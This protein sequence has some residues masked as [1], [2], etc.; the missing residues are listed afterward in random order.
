MLFS[1]W[2]FYP[3]K[4]FCRN[5]FLVLLLSPATNVFGAF[6]TGKENFTPDSIFIK[7]GSYVILDK[8][9]VYIKND[10]SIALVAGEAG[11]DLLLSVEES[12]KFYQELERKANSS[13]LIKSIY[14]LVFT[15]PAT[16]KKPADDQESGE[17]YFEQFEN[18]II[19]NIYHYS[20][21]VFGPSVYD[22]AGYEKPWVL[23]TANNL[24]VNTNH[25]VI[26]RNLLFTTGEG[27]EPFAFYDNER[28]L[29]SLPFIED[30]RI[31]IVP[32]QSDTS[33]ADV[34][35]ITK[36]A[37][38]LGAEFQLYDEKSGRIDF[39]D[40]NILGTGHHQ[41]NSVYFDSKKDP[42]W[43]YEGFY[44]I[45]NIAGSF[46]D[47][48]GS[49][50]TYG[51]KERNNISLSRDFITPEIK[52]AGGASV[53]RIR[54]TIT[55]ASGISNFGIENHVLDF[56]AGRSIKLRSF[57]KPGSY[58]PRLVFKTRLSF[59]QY[60]KRP[61]VTKSDNTAYTNYTR[62][63]FNLGYTQT[64]FY[65]ASHIYR[66]GRT[67]DV[68]AGTQIEATIGPEKSEF[69]NRFYMGASAV[70]AG[71]TKNIGYA[72]LKISAGTYLAGGKH[73]QSSYRIEGQ[74]FT[75]KIKIG[76]AR[77]RQFLSFHYTR[78]F[79][80][81]ADEYLN[82]NDDYGIR[83]FYADSLFGSQRCAFRIETVLFPQWYYYGFGAAIFAY[84]DGAFLGKNRLFYH[85]HYYSCLGLG[86]RIRNENLVFNSLE[87]RFGWY[88]VTVPGINK[89]ST[90][91]SNENAPPFPGFSN[92]LP[93]VEPYR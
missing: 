43:G 51:Y 20:L 59:D 40:K 53:S 32:N 60:P 11:Q 44:K 37:W 65:K 86:F 24:H 58:R 63:L 41:E 47:A 71:W 64:R 16:Y 49:Y 73:E 52:Y 14:K 45:P 80:R 21:D 84:Y 46:A 74:Y 7:A 87:I 30:A 1:I 90:Y 27:I 81:K 68:P 67:E 34:L 85:N 23:R 31:L 3:M 19:A 26:L 50:Y 54:N 42:A 78:G 39:F 36:D 2:Q 82:I 12:N 48:K 92:S 88:P 69:A 5:V 77:L 83:D 55:T 35:V 29:R 4:T 91:L 18:K 13:R 76:D 33:K 25:K 8:K 22:T 89:Y 66:F 57:N 70:H 93:G 72:A 6:L 75:N 79:D 28:L 10:T 61:L 9:I 15:A 62:L 56:W 38:T 17:K